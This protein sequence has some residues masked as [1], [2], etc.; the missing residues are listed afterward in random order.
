MINVRA[1][2]AYKYVIAARTQT[3]RY[4][5]FQIVLSEKDGSIYVTFPYFRSG[6]GTLGEVFLNSSITYP[7]NLI[8]GQ[9]FAVTTHYVKYSHHPSGRAHFSLDG[10]VKTKVKKQSVP[11]SLATGHLFTFMVQGL[12][13]FES[14]TTKDKGTKKRGVIEFP[15]DSQATV[16]LKFLCFIYSEKELASVIVKSDGSSPYM[17]LIAPDGRMLFGILLATTYEHEGQKRFLMLGTE[18]IEKINKDEEVFMS[19]SGGFDHPDIALDHSKNTSFL[20]FFYPTSQNLSE[21]RSNP[22]C[23]DLFDG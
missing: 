3:G 22:S 9:N 16:A 5:I 20:M 10:K 19:F 12:D 18:R 6:G 15:F 17:T 8:V 13:K 21:I 23:I 14:M 1:Y 2:F 4:K 7:T 11:L